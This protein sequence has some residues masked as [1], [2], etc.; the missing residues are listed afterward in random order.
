MSS[1]FDFAKDEFRHAVHSRVVTVLEE[2]IK[3]MQAN[4][5]AFWH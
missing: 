2:N 5:G 1:T 4:S 3:D